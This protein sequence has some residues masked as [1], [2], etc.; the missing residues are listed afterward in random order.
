MLEL[1]KSQ[2]GNNL[3][4]FEKLLK[5]AQKNENMHNIFNYKLK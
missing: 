5:Y 4:V 2:K 1:I 3:L